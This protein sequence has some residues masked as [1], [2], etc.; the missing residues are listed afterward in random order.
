MIYVNPT[1]GLGN[2]LF[3]I[4]ATYAIALE[5]NDS[6]CLLNTNKFINDLDNDIRLET[7]HAE[8]YNYILNRFIQ[9]NFVLADWKLGQKYAI[10]HENHMFPQIK[11]PFQYVTP[12]YKKEYEYVGYFQSE[13]Y[14]KHKRDDILLAFKPANEFLEKINK[15]FHLFNNISLHVRRGDYVNMHAGRYIYLGVDYYLNAL[16]KLPKYL[17]VLV[18]SDDIKWCKE[19]L[20]DDRFI[21]IDEP[22]YISLYIMS[23]MKYNI[24]ANS[25]FGWWGAWLGEPERVIAPKEWF[26]NS[27][28]HKQYEYDIVPNN[29]IKI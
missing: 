5:H 6:L 22:D 29:W 17:S 7:S 13:K 15:Y 26:G 9:Q 16:E 14:F 1:G 3:Q 10:P 12:E 11:F 18:F 25:S 27:V 8:K 28:V 20:F 23:K 19:N 24:I 21:F 2:A 4:A